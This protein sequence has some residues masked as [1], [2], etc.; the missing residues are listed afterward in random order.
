MGLTVL[1]ALQTLA[2]AAV[3]GATMIPALAATAVQE[4]SSFLRP[5][6]RLQQLAHQLLPQAVGELFTRL[7]AVARLHYKVVAQ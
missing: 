1:M 3:A 7:R 4:L 6:R 2:A 5:K